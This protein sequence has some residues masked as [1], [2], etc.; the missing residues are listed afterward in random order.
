MA[1]LAVT[2]SFSSG[3]TIVASQMNTN[4]DDIESFINSSPGV[5]QLTGGT[6]TGAV[7]LTSTL[8]V[9]ANEAG[10]DVKF[11]GDTIGC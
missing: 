8:T 7:V 6:V 5:L 4:F 2:N 9:G 3:T 10:H 11:F 1:T